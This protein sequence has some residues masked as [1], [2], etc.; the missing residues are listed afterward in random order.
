[1]TRPAADNVKVIWTGT[2]TGTMSLGTAVPGFQ[3]FPAAL[4][5][6]KVSY[7]IEWLIGGGSPDHIER[8][9]GIGTYTASGTTLTRD[10]VTFSTAGAP[11]KVTFSAG[12]KHVRLV[13]LAHEVVENRATSNPTINDDVTAG[14]VAGRS[15]WLNTA[16]S[17]LFE[18]ISDAVGAA[19]WDPVKASPRDA[20]AF[21]ATTTA[22]D[23]FHNTRRRW[24]GTSAGVLS[25]PTGLTSGVDFE[26][27]IDHDLANIAPLTVQRSSSDGAY[28]L[29]SPLGCRVLRPGG[30]ARIRYVEDGVYITGDLDPTTMDEPGSGSG[31]SPTEF[32]TTFLLERGLRQTV[33]GSALEIWGDR[34]GLGDFSVIVGSPTVG[35]YGRLAWNPSAA[36]EYI[37]S[38]AKTFTG[39]SLLVG[40]AGKINA[41]TA[42]TTSILIYHLMD[43]TAGRGFGLRRNIDN[44]MSFFVLTNVSVDSALIFDLAIGRPFALGVAINRTGGYVHGFFDEGYENRE[45]HRL[46]TGLTFTVSWTSASV[47]PRIGSE[48]GASHSID[49]EAFAAT[50]RD[51]VSFSSESDARDQAHAMLAEMRAYYG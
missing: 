27:V 49:A 1:M 43:Y 21:T 6:H 16:T 28:R 50:A 37:E 3:A 33:S 32:G 35:S 40:F 38:A 44:T 17:Q 10:L 8:E 24:Q 51:N 2:G 13:A 47:V 4:D 7:A 11:T 25:A 46:F 26:V 41:F 9:T 5:G 42:P 19:R 15:R 23:A 12:T 36:N 20:V 18:L 39:S 34:Y 29:G 22:T 45:R 48:P 31:G 30:I 14:Y